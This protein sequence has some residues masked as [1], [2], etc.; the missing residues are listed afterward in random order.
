MHKVLRVINNNLDYYVFH[1]ALISLVYNYICINVKF[2]K[3][4]VSLFFP[5]LKSKCF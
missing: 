1:L 2:E 5:A 3:L 4:L